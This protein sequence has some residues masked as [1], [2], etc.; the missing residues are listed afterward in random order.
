MYDD[1]HNLH[2]FTIQGSS[3]GCMLKPAQ[4]NATKIILHEGPIIT[5]HSYIHSWDI[6]RSPDLVVLKNRTQ[7]SNMVKQL[8]SILRSLHKNSG[9]K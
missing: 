2:S 3:W 7:F 1:D 5:F 9:A 6:K 4:L 8:F